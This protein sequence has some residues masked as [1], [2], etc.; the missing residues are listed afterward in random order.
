MDR[1][2]SMMAG[3][4]ANQILH[5]GKRCRPAADQGAKEGKREDGDTH[6]ENIGT[7]GCEEKTG[8]VMFLAASRISAFC[9]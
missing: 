2:I 7:V 4:A 3:C 5:L 9:R 8:G 1:G 6:V